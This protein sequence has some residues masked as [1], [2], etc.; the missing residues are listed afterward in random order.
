MALSINGTTINRV[1]V[2]DDDQAARSAFDFTLEELGVQPVRQ[3]QDLTGSPNDVLP[4]LRG[5][6]DALVSDYHLRKKG[7]YAHF[8]GDALVAAA[9][10]AHFPALLCTS[11]A[12]ALLTVRRNLRRHIPTLLTA[13][14]YNPHSFKQG[15]KLC[16]EESK[17]IFDPTRKPWRS[18][19]RVED[20]ERERGYFYVVVVGWGAEQKIPIALDEVPEGIRAQL[21]AGYRLHA[22]VNRGA[23]RAEDLFFDEWEGK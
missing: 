15:I 4:L 23:L 7:T 21:K 19:V 10:A 2:V 6:A 5:K 11:Y 3:E 18:L 14:D 1:V 17:G 16:V 12:D 9:N 22:K 8:E 13:E 20:I